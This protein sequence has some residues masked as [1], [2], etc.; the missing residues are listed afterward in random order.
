MCFV[1][2]CVTN[3]LIVF[4]NVILYSAKTVSVNLFLE[5]KEELGT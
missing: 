4:N 1:F 2:V 5:E 3:V